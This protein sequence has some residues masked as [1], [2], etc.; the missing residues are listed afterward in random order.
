[1]NRMKVYEE[2]YDSIKIKKAGITN[3]FAIRLYFKN[4]IISVLKLVKMI[5]FATIQE[6]KS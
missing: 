2:S 4:K 1:M 5:V 6:C 3:G